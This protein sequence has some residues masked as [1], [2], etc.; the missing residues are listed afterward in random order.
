[1]SL[2]RHV[3]VQARGLAMLGVGLCTVVL[4]VAVG[5]TLARVQDAPDDAAKKAEYV[6]ELT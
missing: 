6:E 2:Q 5:P 1:M 3:S 4:G